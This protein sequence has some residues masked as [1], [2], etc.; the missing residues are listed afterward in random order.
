MY[1][2][3][4]TIL[5]PTHDVADARLM[6]SCV[7]VPALLQAYVIDVHVIMSW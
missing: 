1:I 4:A 5:L 2:Y 3:Y 6:F 7:V